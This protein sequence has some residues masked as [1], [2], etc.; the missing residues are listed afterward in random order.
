[1]PIIDNVDRL[2]L[3][4]LI[5]IKENQYRNKDATQ[6]YCPFSV[7]ARINELAQKQADRFT[8]K[9]VEPKKEPSE[10]IFI[11]PQIN[12]Q[13]KPSPELSYFERNYKT[14]LA[15]FNEYQ[16]MQNEN[17]KDEIFTMCLLLAFLL[18]NLVVLIF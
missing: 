18:M 15:L 8:A 17:R 13:I 2:G 14:R 7:E 5:E 1:M 6:D 9:F 16:K 10:P 11:P 4:R 3:K 12:T